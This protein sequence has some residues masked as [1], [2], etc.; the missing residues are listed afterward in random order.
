Y[1]LLLKANR[2][3][4]WIFE[5]LVN[6]NANEFNFM[7]KQNPITAV[8]RAS[9]TMQNFPVEDVLSANVLL[10]Y[11]RADI[12]EDFL[13]MLTPDNCRVTIVGKIFESEADQCEI[14]SGIKY[15]VAN[16]EDL[17]KN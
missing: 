15:T 9:N 3:Q 10:D 6:I 7:D 11:F 8:L 4:Q 2:P 17:Y 16:M 1:L 13:N 5:E 12:I 14:W